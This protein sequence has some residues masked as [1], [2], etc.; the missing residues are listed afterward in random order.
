MKSNKKV[1]SKLLGWLNCMKRK[2]NVQD[3]HPGELI[4]FA[5]GKIA[6]AHCGNQLFRAEFGSHS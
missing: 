3:K 4:H 2:Q 1:V 6:S 5:F